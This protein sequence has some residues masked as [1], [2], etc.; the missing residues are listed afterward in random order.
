MLTGN[1]IHRLR[2]PGHGIRGAL[3][4]EKKHLLCRLQRLRATF[5]RSLRQIY[6]YLRNRWYIRYNPSGLRLL[7]SSPPCV[8]KCLAERWDETI[9]SAKLGWLGRVP[10]L[11]AFVCIRVIVS[12]EYYPLE[13]RSSSSNV[14]GDDVRV[15]EADLILQSIA[16]IGKDVI[17]PEEKKRSIIVHGQFFFV[18]V[19][20]IFHYSRL[21]ETS[22]NFFTRD[23]SSYIIERE[24]EG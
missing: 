16:R 15:F 1:V 19:K 3:G 11:H 18:T 23:S 4:S 14:N 5:T 9:L 7:Q 6:T 2:P 21:I 12:S 13:E 10:R 22:V 24:R 8:Y 17:V 20:I